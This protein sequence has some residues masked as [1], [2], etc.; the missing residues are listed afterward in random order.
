MIHLK[1]FKTNVKKLL[2]IF[3][4]RQK[5]LGFILVLITLFCA[6]L[7]TLCVYIF[8]PIVSAM[9][10]PNKYMNSNV[11]KIIKKYLGDISFSESFMCIC[12]I[13]AILYLIKETML[14]FQLWYSNRVAFKIS[15]ELSEQ[16]L[17]SYMN[18]EY[19][20][21]LNYG[22]SKIMRDVQDDTKSVNSILTCITNL[23]TEILTV[24]LIVLY[25]A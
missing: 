3:T 13:V 20:F 5:I 24:F 21:F 11:A 23:I 4:K 22:T 8:S 15:R 17:N 1:S 7:N 14:T 25:I 10:D 6:I 9:T 16:V 18:M 2:Y 19:D 12:I